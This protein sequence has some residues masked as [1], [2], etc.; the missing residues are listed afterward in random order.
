MPPEIRQIR[1]EDIES[2][3]ETVDIVARERRYLYLTEAP[4]IDR[5]RAFVKGNI[6]KGI[7]HLVAASCE[8]VVGWC[9]LLPIERPVQSHVA[10]LAMGLRPEWRGQGWGATL[11]QAAL[12]AGDR[13]GFTRIEL[14]VFPHNTRAA[15]LYRKLGFV[16]EGIKRHSVRID[17]V[18]L[19]EIMMVRFNPPL[20]DPAS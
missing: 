4:P 11:M 5:V 10:G 9:V 3:R 12:N 13:Y 15:A 8:T 16:K 7:P 20:S 1:E 14:T 6:D 18:Y 2:F 19:D 17:E